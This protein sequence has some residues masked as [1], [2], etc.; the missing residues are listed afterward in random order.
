MCHLS[1]VQIIVKFRINWTLCT[2]DGKIWAIKPVGAVSNRTASARPDRSGSRPV[3]KNSAYQTWG[4]Q[5]S[6]CFYNPL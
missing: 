3:G 6:I 4:A 5:V 1:E 2:G